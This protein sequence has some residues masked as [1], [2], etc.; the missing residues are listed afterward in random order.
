MR[1]PASIEDLRL[2]ARAR[3]PRMVFD[4]IDGG[5]DAETT[6]R[7]NQS[8]FERIRLRPRSLVDVS[9]RDSSTT[10]FGGRWALPLAIAPTGMSRIAGRGGDLAGA[11]AAA[12][13]GAGFT[14]STMSS[15]SIEEV[16]AAAPD[17]PL[18]FQLYL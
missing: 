3:L 11:R 7:A 10:V 2:R 1:A 6:L 12:R 15:H 8:A 16:A 17:A 18:W 9:A 4:F 5:A 14:L 13:A